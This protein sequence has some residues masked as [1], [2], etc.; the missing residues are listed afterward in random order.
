[1]RVVVE[2]LAELSI[3]SGLVVNVGAAET[4][5]FV[6]EG[7]SELSGLVVCGSSARVVAQRKLVIAGVVVAILLVVAGGLVTERV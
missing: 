6:V 2:G 7:A 4:S 3:M 1:M 5:G